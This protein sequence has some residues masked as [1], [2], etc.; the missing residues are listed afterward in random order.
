MSFSHYSELPP[1]FQINLMIELAG[2]HGDKWRMPFTAAEIAVKVDGQVVGD[3]SLVLRAFAPA[4]RAQPGDLTFAE[5]E[6]YFA[7]AEQSLASAIMVDGNFHSTT[8]VLIRVPNARIAFARV[9]PLFFPEPVY[10]AGIHPTAV[11]HG[12]AVVH[13]TAHVGP[14]CVLGEN[15]RVGARSVL[16]GGNHIGNQ[17][18]LGEDVNLFPNVVLYPRT[19][20][21]NRVRLHAGVVIGADGFG[22]VLDCGSQRKVP[23]IGNVIIRDDVEIGANST[24]DRGALGPT[25]IGR[26]SKIDNLVQIGHNCVLGEHCLLVAQVG[27]AGSSRL[28]NYVIL[29]GQAG[30]AGHLK[31]GNRVSVGAQAGVM[32]SIPDGEKW[33]GSPA[34][35]DRTIKRQLISAHHL[36]ELLKRVGDLEKK[37]GI[38]DEAPA[39]PA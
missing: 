1:E 11:V 21:G 32:N 31:I 39:D 28:G 25:V 9:L 29:G 10:P 22:Y 6:S 27:V 38:S 7:R 30:I 12:S 14:N 8:K 20:L 13:P 34:G 24:V 33:F 26:G 18:L 36:P 17:C 3:P 5:N 15:V 37:L 16:Q 4:D 35:P 2:R 19:E 23:Q